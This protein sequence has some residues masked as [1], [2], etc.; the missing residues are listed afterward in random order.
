MKNHHNTQE[1]KLPR[2]EVWRGL[3]RHFP[4]D[5]ECIASFVA[6]EAAE[7][8]EGIKPGNLVSIGGRPQR[9]GRNL[10]GL[11]RRYGGELL[12]ESGLAAEVL[13]EEDGMILLYFYRPAAL[14]RLLE[15]RSVRVILEKAGYPRPARAGELF[16]E[17]RKRMKR[18]G[19]PHEIGIFLGYPLKDV[20][21]FMGWVAIPFACQGPWKI[22]G[23]PLESLQ[24]AFRFREC[25]CRMASR[26]ASCGTPLD[27]LRRAA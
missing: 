18:G 23:N 13:A 4:D 8:I 11:W 24:L 12:A 27:C 5:R 10:S 19:F 22:Y 15:R 26:L 6:L 16:D 9:C 25:R 17:L 14:D 2:Q 7:V 21:A 3:G 1:V 20:V